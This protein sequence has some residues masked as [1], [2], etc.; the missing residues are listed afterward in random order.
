MRENQREILGLDGYQVLIQ[1][2][3]LTSILDIKKCL[4]SGE[5]KPQKRQD[6]KNDIYFLESLDFSWLVFAG[7][8][9]PHYIQK[10]IKEV[11]KIKEQ[12]YFK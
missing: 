12:D 5:I 3:V 7:F 6:I 10:I 1:V 9:N 11:L 4:D 2:L 8:S